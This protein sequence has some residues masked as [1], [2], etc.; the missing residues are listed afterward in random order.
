[1]CRCKYCEE[2]RDGYFYP[3]DKNAH[4]LIYNK[5]LR[6]NWYGHHMNIDVNYCPMCR[7]KAR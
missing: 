3:L 5:L 7:Q 4:V 2:D 1:M 6:I